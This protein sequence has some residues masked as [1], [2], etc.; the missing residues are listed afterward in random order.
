MGSLTIRHCAFSS[1][2]TLLLTLLCCAT[3]SA[4]GSLDDAALIDRPI[5]AVT[6][7]G[8]NNVDPQL[9]RN[10][11]RAAVGDPYTPQTV[12]ADVARLYQ[13][14]RFSGVT[15]EAELLDDG[16]VSLTY[17]LVEQMI[18]AEVQVVGNT[19]ISD[20]ELRG[21]VRLIRGGPRDDFLV[22]NAV[23]SIQAMYR[24][25]GH[26]LTS[27]EVDESELERSGI[28]L[29]R[30]IEGPRVRIKAVNFQGNESF[31]DRQLSPEISTRTAILILRRGE[32]DEDQLLDDVA[33]LDRFYKDRG[34]LEVRVDHTIELSPDNTEAIVT[35]L[36]AEGPQYTLRNVRTARL[37]DGE[38][39]E[40][41]APQQLAAL[42]DIRSGD[43]Y[44]RDRLRA[45]VRA[46]EDAYGRLGYYPIRV[47]MI[48]LHVPEQAQVD[49]L[50]EIDEGQPTKVGMVNI[51]GNFLTRDRVI[52]RQVRLQPG[53]PLDGTEI[54]RSRRR[55]EDTRLFTEA[56]ITV[57]DPDPDMPD[58]RDVLVEIRE[59]NTGS[60]NF[61]A[62]IGSDSG[63]FGEI[64]LRQDNFDIADFPESFGELIRGRSFRGA[65]QRFNMVFRP[66]NEIFQYSMSFTEPH[67]FDSDYSL[68][69]SGSFRQRLFR[70][71]DEDRI[72]G[73]IS[74]GRR[75]GDV[76][77]LGVRARADRV[78]LSA[79]AP[80]APTAF[81][82]DRG[83]DVLTAAGVSLTRSTVTTIVRPGRGTR[84]SVSLDRFGA[85]GGDYDF[86]NI[87]AEYTIFLTVAEDF[88]GRRSTLRLNTEVGHIF[89][90]RAPTYEQYYR[91]GRTFRGF[92]FREISPKGI[93]NDNNE[94]SDEPV[95]GEWMFFA[96]AQYEFPIFGDQVTG[97]L[98][99]DS[100]TVTDSVGFDDYRVSVGTG[101]RLYIP[102]FGP[103]PIAFDFGF[104]ILKEDSDR[105]QVLSFSAE[106]PF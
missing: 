53:R 34:F 21:V 12:R 8:L 76:W 103:V 104:P 98:F 42:L 56:R 38:P 66:G 62:A 102:Q 74:L 10:N 30:I 97:V 1:V 60:I 82:E 16:T 90:G 24:S 79:I 6:F 28:L 96:G 80:F 39:L 59:R 94:P 5:A 54:A 84:F 49:L 22:D 41:F 95:G 65:G 32:L 87:N 46:I 7:T 78:E 20:Q 29:F 72:T 23:R 33:A 17:V 2:F 3:A 15:A 83:P 69:L 55:I 85:F 27:V 88:L 14:G 64:S 70:Q 99:L 13:L 19:L 75:L 26:Y 58:H 51:Q 105:S 40:V 9:V 71:Y 48:E 73:S 35:Y 36:I 67:L 93:R 86:N 43:V 81:F 91:G 4:Q 45:S 25:R 50:L 77:S 92:R 100:G 89:G 37:I 11:I 44:S 52:R 106:L 31:E 68:T 57:Q 101:V 63:V 61:G 18:I 47:E